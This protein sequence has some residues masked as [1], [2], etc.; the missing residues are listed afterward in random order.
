MRWK[1]GD[2][3]VIALV[4]TLAAALWIFS[5]AGATRATACVIEL[6]G[7]TYA[8]YRLDECHTPKTVDIRTER[9]FNQVVIDQRGAYVSQ[10]DCP[11]GDEVK[12]GRLEKAGDTAVCL[13]HRL[14]VRLTGTQQV[15]AVTE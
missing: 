8:T 5:A 2:I 11:N 12:R 7:H 13:P 14:V 15:D 4:I 1:T 10:S 6:D 9:G 3:L